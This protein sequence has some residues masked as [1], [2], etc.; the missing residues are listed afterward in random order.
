MTNGTISIQ[1]PS[2]TFLT[3][4]NIP[5]SPASGVYISQLIRYAWACSKYDQILIQCSLLTNKLMSHG[6]LQ[7]RL[8]TAFTQMLRSLQRSSLP[9]QLSFKPNA[10]WCVWYQSL[11]RSWYTDLDYDS[12]RLPDLELG[13]T[14]GVTDQQGMLTPPRYLIPLL[15]Y[16]CRGS[17]LPYSQICIS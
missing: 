3:C 15:V 4:S 10:V 9:L 12:Y 2:T 13:L 11:S 17:C 16:P 14:T 1:Y 8:Q 7:S 5:I 6:F